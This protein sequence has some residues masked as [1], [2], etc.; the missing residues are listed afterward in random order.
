MPPTQNLAV[1]NH[2]AEDPAKKQVGGRPDSQL[3]DPLYSIYG[4]RMKLWIIFLVSISGVISP[5]G[6]T[7][8][9]PALNALAEQLQIS[10]AMVNASIT[11]Y[12]VCIFV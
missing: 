5:F 12:M 3:S 4:P 8:F 11:T 6:A 7:T 9:F 10:S 2:K 1:E